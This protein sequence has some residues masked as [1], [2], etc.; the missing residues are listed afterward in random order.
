[1]ARHVMT[2]RRRVAL[3]KAQLAS[4]KKR[5]RRNAAIAVGVL[6]VAGGA[7]AGGSYALNH[8]TKYGGLGK[9]IDKGIT[10]SYWAGSGMHRNVSWSREK[11]AHAHR[12]AGTVRA[13]NTTKGLYQA[14][15]L[16]PQQRVVYR[17][18]THQR[19]VHRLRRIQGK[20]PA[21]FNYGSGKPHWALMKRVRQAT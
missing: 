1:M 2:A 8:P 9:K 14:G 15:T 11:K 12:S 6:A 18:Y 7:V 17:E 16:N 20:K 13:F 5:R 21:A 3:R 4:A 10:F 19:A